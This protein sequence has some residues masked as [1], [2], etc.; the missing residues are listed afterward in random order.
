MMYIILGADGKEYGP[1]PADKVRDWIAGGRANAQ[2][3]IK[4]AGTDQWTTIGELPDFAAP[5]EPPAPTVAPGLPPAAPA[6]APLAGTP[7]EIAAT[8]RARAPKLDPFSCLSRS[9]E[10]WKA[11]LLPLVGVTLLIMLVQFAVGM[12]PLLGTLS[13]LFLNGVFYG[14]LY[15][16]YLG[17]MRGEPRQLGDAFAGFSKA[18]VPLMIA[19][20]LVAL[21]TVMVIL[22]FLGPFLYAIGKAAMAG[23][24]AAPEFSPLIVAGFILGM[25]VVV[26]L[27]ISWMFTFPLVMDKGLGPWTAMEVSRRVIS[28]QWFR[29]FFVLILA[30]LVILLG[31]LA[32]IVGLF[33]AIPLGIGA[34]LYAYEDLCNPPAA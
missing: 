8:L 5:A 25:L 30:C 31:V 26:Y 2:T 24:G 22:P 4:V 3:R 23:G 29:M 20:L 32:L 1:V 7:A 13:G 19:S 10:L 15:Y 6:A 14:G 17:H 28:A 34:M 9:F 27:S 11:N 12:I 33:F 18:F 16:Y 21:L